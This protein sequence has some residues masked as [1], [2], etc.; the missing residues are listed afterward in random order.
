MKDLKALKLSSL[1][2]DELEKREMNKLLGG[3]NCCI[4]GCSGGD[5]TLETGNREHSGGGVHD[6]G[7]YGS[8]AYGHG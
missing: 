1:L 4:C 8:G 3:E 2:N 6:A 7:G 5:T